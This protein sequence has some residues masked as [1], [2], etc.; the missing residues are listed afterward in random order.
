M[1]ASKQ[2][3]KSMQAGIKVTCT[4]RSMEHADQRSWQLNRNIWITHKLQLLYEPV[5]LYS[6]LIHSVVLLYKNSRSQAV[7]TTGMIISTGGV[8]TMSAR[9]QLEACFAI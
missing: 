3:H 9:I 2:Y 6:N 1:E 5:F 7:L 8:S 4:S